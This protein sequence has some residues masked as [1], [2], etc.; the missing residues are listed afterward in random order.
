MDNQYQNVYVELK[1]GRVGMFSGPMLTTNMSAVCNISFST[2][3]EL[4]EQL[5]WD[6]M[7]L[8]EAE[9]EQK[10]KTQTTRSTTT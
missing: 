5:T 8:Q 4:P 3:K 9:Y 2:P 10:T 7:F 6:A 1:D